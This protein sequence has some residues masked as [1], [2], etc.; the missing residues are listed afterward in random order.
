MARGQKASKADNPVKRLP[1]A[2][3]SHPGLLAERRRHEYMFGAVAGPVDN[4]EFT[5][6][7]PGVGSYVGGEHYLGGPGSNP[8]FAP[9]PD[10]RGNPHLDIHAASMQVNYENAMA[11]LM[12]QPTDNAPMGNLKMVDTG[13]GR[14]ST[15]KEY[16][17]HTYVD[18]RI[19][20]KKSPQGD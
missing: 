15:G 1:E 6:E 11:G 20:T 10:Y 12:R 13:M 3:V 5:K 7:R 14:L 9:R 4:G 18:E 2:D 16:P 8:A 17:V 19:K